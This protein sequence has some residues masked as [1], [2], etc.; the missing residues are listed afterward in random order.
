M[1]PSNISGLIQIDKHSRARIKTSKGLL[2]LV[3]YPEDAPLSMKEM[4]VMG[5]YLFSYLSNKEVKVSGEVSGSRLFNAH[6]AESKLAIKDV[7][8]GPQGSDRFSQALKQ[9]FKRD[10][11]QIT[12]KLNLAGITTVSAF[13]HRVK[14]Y[15]PEVEAFSRYLRVPKEA[16]RQF[17]QAIDTDQNNR[18]LVAA[19]PRYPVTRG[20]NLA[21]ISRAIGVPVK[22]YASATPPPFPDSA[23]TPNLPSKV[24]LTKK[25]TKVRDQGPFRGTCVAHTAAALLEFELIYNGLATKR[26]DLSEQYLYWACKQVDG[27]SNDDGTFIE[28]AMKVLLEGVKAEGYAGGVCKE[29]DWPYNTV[30]IAGNQSQGPLPAKTSRV[31][32]GLKGK[33]FGISGSTE[34]KSNS[35]KDLKNALADNHC[36]GLSVYTYHFWTDNYTWREGVISLPFRIKPDGAHAICLVGYKDNDATHSDGYFIFKNSWG[37]NWGA[38]RPDQGFGSLPY[39][40]V[41]KESIEAWYANV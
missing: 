30:S 17:L 22:K 3:P 12:A 37:T 15:Q 19:V 16:I 32:K 31:M 7:K 11:Q 36:V 29:Q 13:Y 5:K 25:I 38:G 40:Y 4:E 23:K 18:A 21:R 1:P 28:Y 41:L 34:L 9:Y 26:L 20:V 33:I 6:L 14:N 10:S 35:I 8:L 2:T 39:R 27:A 24:M